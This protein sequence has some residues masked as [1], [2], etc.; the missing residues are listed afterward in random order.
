MGL[1]ARQSNCIVGLLSGGKIADVS[2]D[3]KV[4]VRTLYRWLDDPVFTCELR[5]QESAVIDACSWQL[6]GISRQA[7]EA[8]QDVIKNPSQPGAA[9]KRQAA[10]SVLVL[11]LKWKETRDFEERLCTLEGLINDEQRAKAKHVGR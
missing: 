3:C 10:V 5:R 9:N 1:S 2:R 8:L 6:V 4:S 7:V 11:L